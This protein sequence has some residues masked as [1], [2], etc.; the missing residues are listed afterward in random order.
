MK[1]FI[2]YLHKGDNIPC[3]IGKTKNKPKYRLT[4]HRRIKK[5]PLYEIEVIDEVEDWRFWETYYI[6][7]FTGWGFK[8]E[9]GNKGGGGLNTHSPKTRIKISK[10]LKGRK[11]TW[12]N[13]ISQKM[14]MVNTKGAVYQY[15]KEG[16][17]IREWEAACVAEDY[18]N[19]GDRRRRDNIRANIRGEQKSAYEYIWR[20][21]K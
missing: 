16:V 15:S 13:N 2:Y 5:Q 4:S 19:P 3:Y 10:G 17:F 18:F 20:S 14:M 12:G 9:N 8:L 21:K 11:I 6:Q 1:S 7:L